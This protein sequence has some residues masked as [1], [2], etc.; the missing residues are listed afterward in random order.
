MPSIPPTAASASPSLRVALAAIQA[1]HRL[2]GIARIKGIRPA[3]RA[4]A[5]GPDVLRRM[6]ATTLEC[7]LPLC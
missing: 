7:R 5:V 4:T 1:A 2:V 3:K 6:L